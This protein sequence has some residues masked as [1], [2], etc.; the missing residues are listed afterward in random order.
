MQW[1]GNPS[2]LVSIPLLL[3]C[4]VFWGLLLWTLKDKFL[5]RL[6]QEQLRKEQWLRN[7]IAYLFRILYFSIIEDG[8]FFCR[9]VYFKHFKH[10]LHS[11]SVILRAATITTASVVIA[12]IS[13]TLVGPTSVTLVT[14]ATLAA[15]AAAVKYSC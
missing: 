5:L 4:S 6:W 14:S 9:L 7:K 8:L 15:F 12:I 10:F 2:I 3:L 13:V 1:P 11:L